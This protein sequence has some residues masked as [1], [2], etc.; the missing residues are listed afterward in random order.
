M[1]SN[2]RAR[3]WDTGKA[4]SREHPLAGCNREANTAS[5]LLSPQPLGLRVFG[6]FASPSPDGLVLRTAL[7]ASSCLPTLD[8]PALIAWARPQGYCRCAARLGKQ[9]T[10]LQRPS[11]DLISGSLKPFCT[12]GA[13]PSSRDPFGS[14]PE[15]NGKRSASPPE[16]LFWQPP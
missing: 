12:I 14:T 6:C 4:A 5:V 15:C 9:S 10:T 16:R 11:W 13:S 1:R 8:V 2:D 3:P 7:Q